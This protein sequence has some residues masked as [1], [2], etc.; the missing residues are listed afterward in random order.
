MATRVKIR[1]G[2]R[3]AGAGRR[4]FPKSER[5]RL[6]AKAEA[7]WR[8]WYGEQLTW[9]W[10]RPFVLGVRPRTR[11]DAYAQVADEERAEGITPRQVRRWRDEYLKS[12][13]Y[14]T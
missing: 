8:K 11:S 13:S 9:G 5:L 3:R 10:S 14:K 1:H 4:T 12:K 6:G 7:I 2:G